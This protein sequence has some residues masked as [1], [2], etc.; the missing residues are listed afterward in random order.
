MSF[1]KSK[2]SKKGYGKPDPRDSIGGSGGGSI[3]GGQPE[4]SSSGSIGVSGSIRTPCPF[5]VFSRRPSAATS[6]LPR[7]TDLNP[8]R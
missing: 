8:N 2:S 1:A 5:P 3:G 4:V 6:I 7:R